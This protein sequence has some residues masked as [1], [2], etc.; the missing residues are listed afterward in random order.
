[1]TSRRPLGPTAR[2]L[3]RATAAL[4]TVLAAALA[5][6]LGAAPAHAVQASSSGC[7][8]VLII[9]ARGTGEPG[10]VGAGLSGLV[11][12]IQNG[13]SKKVAAYGVPYPASTDFDT[14]VP[15]GVSRLTKRATKAVADCPRQRLVL[16]G[17]SQGAWVVGDALDSPN[18]NAAGR[19]VAAV[20][21]YGDPRFNAAESYDRGS[22]R[23]GVDGLYPR[24]T[25]ALGRYA[26]RVRS[27]CD[28]GD[29]VC[30]NGADGNAHNLYGRNKTSAASTF[31]LAQ[32]RSSAG[33]GGTSSGPSSATGTE[34]GAS[35]SASA[36]PVPTPS[37]I[38]APA[39]LPGAVPAGAAWVTGRE[40]A[41]PN[42]PA[43]TPRKPWWDVLVFWD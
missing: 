32:L 16:I 2:L 25:G 3:A 24:A 13:T 23:A 7:A 17:Y 38:P 33:T 8:D 26:S 43:P 40:G 41:A 6:G 10:N 11:S 5:T 28:T 39:A 29:W 35:A 20:V 12:A 22:F 37:T 21:L 30:Q 9:A 42:Y 15:D 19:R 1:M 27:Y 36:T 14:S 31:V 18:L 4:V 34:P